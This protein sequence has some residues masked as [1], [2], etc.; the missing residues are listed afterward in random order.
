MDEKDKPLHSMAE[1]AADGRDIVD[2]DANLDSEFLDAFKLISKIKK[3]FANAS[4]VYNDLPPIHSGDR[5]GHLTIIEKIGAGGM[6]L[7]FKAYDEILDRLVA[8]KFLNTKSSA[9]TSSE[10]FIAEAR[11]IA[12]VRHP[13]VLAIHGANTHADLTG[14]W[15]ELIQGRT[16]DQ[17][18]EKGLDWSQ[19]LQLADDLSNAL[20]IIHEN[21]IVHGD[22]KPLNIM[23]DNTK[24]A[25]LMDFGSGFDIQNTDNQLTSSTPSIMAPEL[26]KGSTK[27]KQTDIYALGTVYYFISSGGVFPYQASSYQDLENQVSNHAKINFEFLQ[28]TRKWKQLIHGM[29]HHNAD[30]RPSAEHVRKII[31]EIKQA[32]IK[33]NKR[34]AL[35]SLLLFLIGT[36]IILSYSYYSLDKAQKNTQKAL[37]ETTEVNQLMSQMLSSVSPVVK[38]KDVLMLDVIDELITE[39]INNSSISDNVK[40]R[41]LLTLAHSLN[42]LDQS[43]DAIALLEIILGYPELVDETKVHTLCA[44]ARFSLG[45]DQSTLSIQLAQKKIN[46]AKQLLAG[47][48]EGQRQDLEALI[49]HAQAQTDMAQEKWPAAEENINKAIQYWMTLRPSK[50]INREKGVLLN[51]LGS[52]A[53]ERGEFA[54]AASYFAQAVSFFESFEQGLNSNILSTKNNWAIN[55]RK[56]GEVEE[57]I[58]LYQ[59]LIEQTEIFIGKDHEIYLFL[60]QNLAGALNDDGQIDASIKILE[61]ISPSMIQKF[62][63]ESQ[64]YISMRTTLA[65][66]LKSLQDFVSAEAIY[67]EVINLAIKL[68]GENHSEVLLNQ[69]NL[70]ELYYESD[71]PQK[72]VNLL[73]IQLPKAVESLGQKHIISVYMLEAFAWSKYLIGGQAEEAL[74]QMREAVK[75]KRQVFGNS[76]SVTK[77][78]Q[79]KLEIIESAQKD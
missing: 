5:W 52:I 37:F 48:A 65:N 46:Q 19:L 64:A 39:T 29:L 21:Q 56:S 36:T 58:D 61:S 70:A 34:L 60:M 9:F 72:A 42:G 22:I 14:F 67:H 33:R 17:H 24:G 16:L 75:L 6:G 28:G 51:D 53:N 71:N 13:N 77:K 8:V 41:S 59:E 69:Y 49:L 76:N 20:A 26:F 78:A 1:A 12:K 35:S 63:T 47:F 30:K 45:I 50:S 55:L 15:A 43:S 10:A 73:E 4:E 31:G 32:P 11:R 57:A 74:F 54:Q 25:I 18:I 2:H 27:T 66:N 38:G 68:Y 44:H 40:A 79:E 23:I 7:V 62:G 3:S